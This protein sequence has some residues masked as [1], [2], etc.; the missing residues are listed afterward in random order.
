MNAAVPG[1]LI[2]WKSWSVALQTIN[3]IKKTMPSVGER[4]FSRVR[5]T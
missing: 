1:V 3:T 5:I 4:F 2:L